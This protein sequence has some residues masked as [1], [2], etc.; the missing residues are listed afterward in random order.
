MLRL[1][2]ATPMGTMASPCRMVV[3]D[4][5]SWSYQN[6]PSEVVYGQNPLSVTSYLPDTSKVQTMDHTLHTRDVILCILKDNLVMAQ[7]RMKQQANQHCLEW[8][9]E[10][11]DM[12]FLQIQPY[13]QTSQEKTPQ[14]IAPK[15][16]GQYEIIQHIGQVAYKLILPTHSMIHLAFH[17]SCLKKVTGSKCKV[18]TSLPELDEEGSI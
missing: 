5:L 12:A 4:L 8:S 3:Q 14:K 18:Q 2:K 11:I 15:F 6:T 13:K 16:Y 17:M 7:N 9:F 10:T 1:K